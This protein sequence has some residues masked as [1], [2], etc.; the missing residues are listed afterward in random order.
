MRNLQTHIYLTFVFLGLFCSRAGNVMSQPRSYVYQH[1]SREDG[2]ASSIVLAIMQDRQGYMWFGSENGLQRYDGRQ[3]LHYR[4]ELN[5]PNSLASDVVEALLQDKHG[6]IWIASPSQVTRFSPEQNKFT[7]IPILDAAINRSLPQRWQLQECGGSMILISGAKKAPYLY[8]A[9][10]NGFVPASATQGV[11]LSCTTKAFEPAEPL[12]GTEPYVYLQDKQGTIW[13]AGERLWNRREGRT[14][15]ELV[16]DSKDLRHGLR[17]NQIYSI[18]Q[19]REGTIWLGT[20][21]GVYFFNPEK[22]RF[23]HV[24]STGG[25]EKKAGESFVVTG[26]LETKAGEVLVASMNKGI[27]VYDRDLRLRRSYALSRSGKQLQ[28]WCLVEDKNKQV[29]A[30]ASD[31]TLLLLKNNTA[32]VACLSP[33]ALAG[34]VVVKAAIDA[35]GKIWWG[36]NTGLL[37]QHDPEKNTFKPYALQALL[38]AQEPGQIQRLLFGTDGSLWVATSRAGVLQLDAQTGKVLAHYTT[39]TRPAGLLSNAVG[40]IAWYDKQ[41]LLISTNFG[42]SFLDIISKKVKTLTTADG[43]PSN[44]ILNVVKVSERHLYLTS[45]ASLSRWN[46][47]TNSSTSYGFRDG[48]IDEA[49]AFNTGYQLRD[50]RI[51]LGTLQGFY[52]FHPDSLEK[53]PVPPN[54]LITG[55]RVFDKAIPFNNANQEDQAISLAYHQNFFTIEFAALDYYNEAQIS[56]EYQLEGVDEAWRPGGHNRFASYTNLDGGNYRFKVRA[57]RDDGASSAEVTTLAL[58][59]ANPFW[60]TGW[61]WTLVVLALAGMMYSLYKFRINR[62]LALQQVRTRI[63]RDLHDDM[64]STLSTITIFSDMANQQVLANPALAQGYLNKISRYSHDMMATMDDIVWSINPQNDSLQNLISRMRELATELLE[65]KGT[66]F[67]IQAD[68]ALNTLRLPLESRYDCFMIYKEALNNLAKYSGCQQVRIKINL[69]HQR[70]QLEII[71]DGQGFDVQAG[72]IG[73]GLQNMQKRA[74][75]M[76]G[77][78]EILSAKG[79]GTTVCLT[80]PIPNMKFKPAEV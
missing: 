66:A 35:A 22:Q 61:F 64:G 20:D 41:T 11:S 24:S 19:N 5:N 29:W 25:S 49:Y 71:D 53:S 55:F 44:T 30:G 6:G 37:V 62:L 70:L 60:K 14:A 27:Q 48:L 4:F 79:Q 21:K 68:A 77:H 50:G 7:R 40:E 56:Y 51:L 15:F 47:Q 8:D 69:E 59:I 78:L 63:A 34:H 2:L 10:R 52:Y 73:N 39:A 26:F 28:A 9:K 32:P 72:N 13:A 58:H 80:I 74:S 38:P 75:N 43:L 1:L 31:G 3:F 42:L 12:P 67:T 17:Y 54:V 45:Q 65:A 57:R 76:K 16:P 23:F 18:A 33:L 46:T 36:T